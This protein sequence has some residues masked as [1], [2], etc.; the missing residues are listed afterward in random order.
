MASSH[1]R[2]AGWTIERIHK[3]AAT[4]GPATAALCDLILDKRTHPEQGFRSCLG[5]LRLGKR[6]G[7][8]RLEAACNRALRV[9]ARS[10]RHVESILKNGLDRVASTDEQTSLSLTHEN[11]RG[12]DYYH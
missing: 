9:R 5:I 7:D 6:Y 1:R 2:Y 3:D 11:V 4:I 10:Y 8:V 12:R